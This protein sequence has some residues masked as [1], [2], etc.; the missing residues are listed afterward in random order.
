MIPPSWPYVVW[1]RIFS[2]LSLRSV[3]ATASCTSPSTSFTKWPKETVVTTINEA[4][5]VTF[6][7][8]VVYH[9]GISN[10]IIHD[11][12]SKFKSKVFQGYCDDIDITVYYGFVAHQR[13]NSQV[14]WA[15]AK[16]L[17]GLKT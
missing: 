9:F 15:N 16:I 2:T 12:G 4:Y 14:E 13:S 8:S 7:K 5:A 6:L 10:L 3:V 1:G 17:K 11:H